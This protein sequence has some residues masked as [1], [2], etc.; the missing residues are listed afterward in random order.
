MVAMVGIDPKLGWGS[1]VTGGLDLYEVP[2]HHMNMFKEPYIQ[3]L[4]EN[5]RLA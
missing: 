1:L 4:A 3:V 5:C 2:G